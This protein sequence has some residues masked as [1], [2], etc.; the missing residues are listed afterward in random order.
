MDGR[1]LWLGTV[2]GSAF[3]LM[4]SHIGPTDHCINTGVKPL[5][6]MGN[7]ILTINDTLVFFA[8]S[9]RLL[10]FSAIDKLNLK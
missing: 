3:T 8:I 1:S 10:S 7:I 2:T 6:S 9:W 4:A 5:G